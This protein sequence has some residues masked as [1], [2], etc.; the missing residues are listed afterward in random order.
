MMI[1]Y[2]I[3]YRMEDLL[4]M[5]SLLIG[6]NWPRLMK[7]KRYGPLLI[8]IGDELTFVQYLD[9]TD[10][11]MELWNIL[12]KKIT[13]RNILKCEKIMVMERNGEE[14]R[15]KDSSNGEPKMKTQTR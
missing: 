4:W 5:D 7:E 6:K 14:S 15:F 12:T 9:A 13:L 11:W 8:Y 1:V 3:L 10:S 2:N